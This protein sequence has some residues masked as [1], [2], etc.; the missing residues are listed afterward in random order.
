V[1]ASP[2]ARL[3]KS[4][5]AAV[6]TGSAKSSGIPCA[7]VLTLIARSPRGPGLIA[8]VIARLV[9]ARFGLSV[10]RPG[11]HAFAVRVSVVRLRASAAT[12]SRPPHPR[13]TCRDDRDTSLCIEAGYADDAPDLGS[14]STRILLIRISP[15]RQT[16]TTGNLRVARKHSVGVGTPRAL[17]RAG[18]Y[19]AKSGEK[20]DVPISTLWA[21]KRHAANQRT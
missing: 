16:G 1:K 10:G 8:P 3:Q 11:P 14:V 18:R 19:S 4:K 2:V 6:T 21:N 9:T 15:L 12:P 17:Q 5:Q 20:A 7:M 13:L